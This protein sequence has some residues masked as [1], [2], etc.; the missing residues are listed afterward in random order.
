M[1]TKKQKEAAWDNA[2]KVR[3]KNPDLYRKDSS[4]NKIYKS[5]YGKKSDMGWE[6]DHKNP[7]SKGGSESTKNVQ[8]LHWEE[9][10]HKSDKYPYKTKK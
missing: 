10:R 4:G 3:G 2:S 9:N 7:K 5:S 8:A 6:V 1:A